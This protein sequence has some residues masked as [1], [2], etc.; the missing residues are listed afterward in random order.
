[1]SGKQA[2]LSWWH[3]DDKKVHWAS[4]RRGRGHY[5]VALC[6]GDYWNVDYR[7]G[8]RGSWRRQLGTAATIAEAKAIAERDRAA[9]PAEIL[10]ATQERQPNDR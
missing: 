3:L 10:R 1:M 8:P 5:V 6:A 4:G 7:R 9:A 2:R